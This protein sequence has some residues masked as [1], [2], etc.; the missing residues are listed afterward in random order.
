MAN[1]LSS[2]FRKMM[3][4]EILRSPSNRIIIAL[5]L[6]IVSSLVGLAI[7]SD[8]ENAEIRACQERGG[9]PIYRKKVEKIPADI[10]GDESV[11]REYKV[12]DR[13]NFEKL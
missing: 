10:R 2:L 6:I 5:A 3:K 1:P 12:F 9:N 4:L 11:E 7:G 13:C 8:R